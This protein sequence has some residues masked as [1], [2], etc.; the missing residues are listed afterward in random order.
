MKKAESQN[1]SSHAESLPFEPRKHEV[2]QWISGL[3][4]TDI[5]RCC[6]LVLPTLKVLNRLPI[7][8]IARFETLEELRPLIFL[9]SQNLMLHLFGARFLL[10]LTPYEFATNCIQLH[11][12]LAYGYELVSSDRSFADPIHFNDLLRARTLHRA[13]QSYSLVM[14]RQALLYQE[15]NFDSWGEVYGLY[16][17]AEQYRIQEIRAKDNETQTES[18]VADVFKCILL[19]ALSETRNHQQHAIVKIYNFLG[20]FARYAALWVLDCEDK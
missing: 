16:S 18:T 6:G 19:F 3:P 5:Q 13:L 15:R 2:R 12:E 20:Q 14:V 17:L 1:G 7:P 10:E 9:L 4:V 8:I 11:R